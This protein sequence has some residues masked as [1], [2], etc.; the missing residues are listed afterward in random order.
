[1]AS[2]NNTKI[3]SKD[4]LAEQLYNYHK[5]FII[6]GIEASKQ[7][8]LE[9]VSNHLTWKNNNT[10]GINILNDSEAKQN[11]YIVLENTENGSLSWKTPIEKQENLENSKLL[12]TGKAVFN[13]KGS[14]NIN[15]LGTVKEGTWEAGDITLGE[16]NLT[17]NEDGK[18]I[19]GNF[20]I[21]QNSE[22]ES[23]ISLQI[24]YDEDSYLTLDSSGE[25]N[26][27][28][29]NT[30]SIN[31]T[32]IITDNATI[33]ELNVNAIKIN[34]FE[35]KQNDDVLQIKYAGNSYLTLDSFGKL[36]TD[37]V[38]T[39]SLI[40]NGDNCEF[41]TEEE[42]DINDIKYMADE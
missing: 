35:I 8:S 23:K 26:T 20:E 21:N 31:T 5:K 11:D 6:N 39:S 1:M 9:I 19:I 4:Y 14:T 37:K 12:V 34:N 36:N 42:F 27:A 30:T 41:A 29:I 18:I 24:K 10:L 7:D 33:F 40:L 32:S 16:H 13:F 3:L 28:S 17:V 15:T 25:L 22:S 38:S 2:T